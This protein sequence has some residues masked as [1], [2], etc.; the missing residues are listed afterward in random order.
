MEQSNLI[1]PGYFDERSWGY[2]L[3]FIAS[4]DTGTQ[5]KNEHFHVAVG[6]RWPPAAKAWSKTQW[7]HFLWP[8]HWRPCTADAADDVDQNSGTNDSMDPLN[9]WLLDIVSINLNSINY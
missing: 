8:A 6:Y 1:F 2:T 7:K 5:Q 4:V 3:I 9:W